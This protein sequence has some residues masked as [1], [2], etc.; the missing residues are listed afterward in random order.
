M[1]KNPQFRLE[2]IRVYDSLDEQFLRRN[3]CF[4]I[5]PIVGTEDKRGSIDYA[6]LA[7]VLEISESCLW[8]TRIGKTGLNLYD[9]DWVRILKHLR[10]H[11]SEKFRNL[12]ETLETHAWVKSDALSFLS[13]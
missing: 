11:N 12:L 2:E 9:E 10:E 4:H 3:D 8:G 1:E 7:E 6:K 13:A 5:P